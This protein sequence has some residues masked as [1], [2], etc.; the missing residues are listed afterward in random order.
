MFATAGPPW[1]DGALARIAPARF[2]ASKWKPEAQSAIPDNQN[3]D[4]QQNDAAN[5]TAND[6]AQQ[7]A[8]AR[9]YQ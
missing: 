6:N 1:L 9:A 8:A 7:C 5:D 3:N 2:L 4:D